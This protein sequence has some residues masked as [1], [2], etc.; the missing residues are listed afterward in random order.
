[1]NKSNDNFAKKALIAIGLAALVISILLLFINGINVF[2]LIFA[3]I[4]LA[5]FLRGIGNILQKKLSIPSN[6]SVTLAI[7]LLI[8]FFVGFGFLM[9]PNISEGLKELGDKIPSSIEKLEGELEEQSWGRQLVENVNKS[10]SD[11]LSDSNIASKVTGIFSTTFGA[12]INIF[13]ILIIGLYL[14]YNPKNYYDGFIKLF[15]K[16]KR[17]R[18]TEITTS[19]K[20]ALGWWMVGQFSS[21]AVVGILTIIG[22]LILGIPLAFTLGIIAAFLTFIPNIGPF[23]AAIPAVLIGLID[24]PLKALYVAILYA[25]IQI[26]ESYLI[27]P[28]IQKKA[29]SLPPALLI[30]VQI[31]IGV[32]LG[33]FGLLLATPLLVA[34]MVL[35]QMAYVEDVIEEDVEVLGSK[36]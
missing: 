18:V 27:T 29:V 1:M 5:I 21:M 15:P 14:A 13:V 22:L 33:I 31:L 3:G 32:W 20:H 11:I 12:I 23:V 16:N 8:G 4:L 35:I 34:V 28:F 6:I 19:I 17:K 9:G 2:L 36:R 30:A 24:S 26:V 7:L 25:G 10:A